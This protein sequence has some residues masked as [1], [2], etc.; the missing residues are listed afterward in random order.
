MFRLF[1]AWAAGARPGDE[2]WRHEGVDAD[3]ATVQSGLPEALAHQKVE[4][5]AAKNGDTDAAFHWA[6]D[7]S[8]DLAA[9][10]WPVLRSA[11]QVLTGDDLTRVRECDSDSCRWLFLDCSR[12]RSR[13]WCDMQVC[14]NRAKARRHYRRQQKSC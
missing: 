2:A 8:D 3:L 5:Q 4:A 13:R 6:W 10:L 12:N 1:A 14:G 9:P 7:E 11:A